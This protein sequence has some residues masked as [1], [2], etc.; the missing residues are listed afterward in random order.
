MKK[1]KAL[2]NGEVA[3]IALQLL[4]AL[5]ERAAVPY[6]HAD[7]VAQAYKFADEVV[8]RGGTE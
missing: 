4:P 2:A 7:I 6:D 8:K 1:I 5:I 3:A